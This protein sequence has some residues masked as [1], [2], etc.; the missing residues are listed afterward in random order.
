[1]LLVYSYF[2]YLLCFFCSLVIV[3][4]SSFPLT[5]CSAL[6]CFTC[7]WVLHLCLIVLNE[8]QGLLWNSCLSSSSSLLKEEE[9][10]PKMFRNCADNTTFRS[11]LS[12]CCHVSVL[13][14]MHLKMSCQNETQ[15]S[16]WWCLFWLWNANFLSEITQGCDIMML[17][18]CSVW[19][20]K[21]VV[22][23]GLH[24]PDILQSLYEIGLWLCSH[25]YTVCSHLTHY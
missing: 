20:T 21:A 14:I 11:Y 8:M 16:N 4:V 7:A 5:A 15:L 6:M 10:Q 18:H 12:F 22:E 2:C 24:C 3:L 13:F 23:K 1:M 25:R 9:K 19:K 17:L